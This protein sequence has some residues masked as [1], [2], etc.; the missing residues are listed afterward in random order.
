MNTFT[1]PFHNKI[2][3]LPCRTI[4]FDMDGVLIDS[5]R[6]IREAWAQV[7]NG[8]RLDG[9]KEFFMDCVGV[10]YEST[11]IKFMA[12]YGTKVS[13]DDFRS[14]TGACYSAMTA[15][16]IPVK[17]GVRELLTSLKQKKWRIGLASSTRR[18]NVLLSLDRTN[19]TEYFDAVL[20][21]DMVKASKPEPDIYLAA[22][23]ALNAKPPGG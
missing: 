5:E 6:L 9:I 16:G 10:S 4:I 14:K 7:G 19:L 15:D 1:A 2:Y 22:C 12:R 23:H 8:L 3:E 17:K 20:C 11:R 13:Y 21:G 18:K